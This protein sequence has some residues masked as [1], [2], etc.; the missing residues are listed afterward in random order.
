MQKNQGAVNKVTKKAGEQVVSLAR[1]AGASSVNGICTMLFHQ[2]KVPKGME[3]L[4]KR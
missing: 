4:K 1:F 3:K 2:P